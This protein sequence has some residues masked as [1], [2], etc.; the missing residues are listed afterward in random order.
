MTVQPVTIQPREGAA[1]GRAFTAKEP[2]FVADARN[3]PALAAPLVEATSARSA[4][5]QPV[6][7]DGEVAGVI[8][9]IWRR[10]LDVLPDGPSAV[11]RLVTAQAAIAIEHAGLRA[12]VQAYTLLV[13]SASGLS[14]DQ[15][16]QTDAPD[17]T[18]LEIVRKNAKV[19]ATWVDVCLFHD[20]PGGPDGAE[21]ETR[22]RLTEQ[23]LGIWHG[24]VPGVE[25]GRR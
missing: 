22:H 7:R 20:G 18:F 13:E 10:A 1:G 25:P 9:V 21:V 23:T 14:V 8:I 19:E 16:A 17:D 6:L 24:A 5:F 3:H 15:F 12:H 11:L 4:V 2:Y